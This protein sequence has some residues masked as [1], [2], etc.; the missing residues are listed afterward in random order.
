[1]A[2]AWRG[3]CVARLV[4]GAACAWRGLCVASL[5][6]RWPVRGAACAWRGLCVARLVRGAA[7]MLQTIQLEPAVLDRAVAAGA[8]GAT[9]QPALLERGAVGGRVQ[10]V[11]PT[12]LRQR[13]R[14][15][16]A[17]RAS[18][19]DAESAFELRDLWPVGRRRA[20][21]AAGAGVGRLGARG[22]PRLSV[23]GSRGHGRSCP[24]AVAPVAV[25]VVK[26]RLDERATRS[27]KSAVLG[28]EPVRL[29]ADA[30]RS[31]AP[32]GV[33]RGVRK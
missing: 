32:V 8:T 20:A 25:I 24:P 5:V 17:L 33:P 13:L 16:V 2:C 23:R 7:A 11:G 31:A 28:S 26:E 10:V 21:G 9:Q 1:M 6:R 30:R 3:L 14:G 22:R 15:A 4:R 19:P 27:W 29:A 12:V 18:Q